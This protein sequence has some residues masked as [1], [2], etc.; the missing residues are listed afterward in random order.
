MGERKIEE[1]EKKVERWVRKE[2][3]EKVGENNVSPVV[4]SSE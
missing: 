2:K 1:E 4:I 3:S